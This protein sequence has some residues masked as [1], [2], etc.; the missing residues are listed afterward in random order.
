MIGRRFALLLALAAAATVAPT[1]AQPRCTQETLAV[2][3]TPVTIAYCIGGPARSD[4]D[5]V[6]VPVSASYAS[7]DGSFSLT[8]ELH[9]VGGEGSSRILESL[10][11]SRIGMTG[12][13]HLTLV[14]AGG[15]VRVEGALLTPGGI[16]IK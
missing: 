13:L 1:A 10:E 5:E 14:Y 16:T 7:P 11:L 15:M 8:R 2:R 3:G 12:V 4:G 9:F 6:I